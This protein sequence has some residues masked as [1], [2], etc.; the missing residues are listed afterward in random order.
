MDYSN[1]VVVLHCGKYNQTE[2]SWDIREQVMKLEYES[3]VITEY[4]EKIILVSCVGDSTMTLTVVYCIGP[5]T[6]FNIMPLYIPFYAYD[7]FL[8]D[9][10]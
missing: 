10:Y 1:E 9:F 6:V 2:I 3:K 8:K 5:Y 7:D 4:T